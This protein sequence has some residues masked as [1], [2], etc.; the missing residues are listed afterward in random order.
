MNFLVSH[1]CEIRFNDIKGQSTVHMHS[2][3]K[4]L[5]Y[6]RL[7]W[8]NEHVLDPYFSI[9]FAGFSHVIKRI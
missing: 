1:M 5:K 9:Q 7:T 2:Y 4:L 8:P 3:A 6:G